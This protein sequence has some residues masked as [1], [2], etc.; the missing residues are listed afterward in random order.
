MV[1]VLN[2]PILRDYFMDTITS[3]SEMIISSV[4]QTEIY[5]SLDQQFRHTLAFS[6]RIRN[7]I[8]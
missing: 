5:W 4:F 3:N 1:M 2:K 7:K 6:K 8:L